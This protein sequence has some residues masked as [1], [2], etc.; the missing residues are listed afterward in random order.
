MSTAFTRTRIRLPLMGKHFT[1]QVYFGSLPHASPKPSIKHD[2]HKRNRGGPAISLQ[3][4][5]LP[6]TNPL[7]TT[8]TKL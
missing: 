8:V 3:D 1:F 4:E 7:T 5:V 2:Y 6:H